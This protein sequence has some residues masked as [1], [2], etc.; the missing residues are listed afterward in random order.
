MYKGS[1]R[2]IRYFIVI[3]VEIHEYEV[4]QRDL[5]LSHLIPTIKLDETYIIVTGPSPPLPPLP[6]TWGW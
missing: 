5:E 2:S 6:L 3:L 4:K 1:S